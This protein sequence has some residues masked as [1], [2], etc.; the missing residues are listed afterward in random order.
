MGIII[1]LGCLQLFAIVMIRG[2]PSGK[3]WSPEYRKTFK[4]VKM[5]KGW[6][7]LFDANEYDISKEG[8]L[9]PALIMQ[10]IAYCI[11]LL[12]IFMFLI[13]YFTTGLVSL[14]CYVSFAVIMLEL[15]SSY[16]VSEILRVIHLKRSR[17]IGLNNDVWFL[18]K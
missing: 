4:L 8:I 1:A 16:V 11:T 12:L 14:S 17:E 13:E 9:L 7:F 10:I 5:K 2:E 6:G 3:H 15:V 18:N